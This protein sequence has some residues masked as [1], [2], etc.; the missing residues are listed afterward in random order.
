MSTDSLAS[1]GES[2]P[3]LYDVVL[4]GTHDSAAYVIRPDLSSRS[5]TFPLRLRAIRTF[6]S[7]VQADFALTQKLNVYQQLLAGARFLDIRVSK[8]PPASGDCQFWTVHGMVLCVPLIDIL[9]QINSFH[10]E[11]DAAHTVITVFRAQFLHPSEEIQLTQFVRQTLQHHVYEGTASQLRHVSLCDLPPNVVAGLRGMSLPVEWGRDAWIDTYS[12]DRKIAFIQ[13]VLL[14]FE[15][16]YDRDDLFV[17]G[18]TVT[19]SVWDVTL[20][21]LSFGYCRPSV[22]AE[23][24]NMNARFKTFANTYP[25]ALQQRCNVIFFD[26]FSHKLGSMVNSLNSYTQGSSCLWDSYDA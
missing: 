11:T 1:S 23:A 25:L 17:L 10:H 21:V 15:S 16:R 26:C 19:P 22:K 4:P 9:Q 20:R 12:C 14:A 5:T 7:T 24:A 13:S 6:L 8:R 18:W 3:T 2:S